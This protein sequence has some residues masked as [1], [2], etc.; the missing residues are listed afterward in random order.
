MKK[1][2]GFQGSWAAMAAASMVLAGCGGG[3]GPAPTPSPTPTPTPANAAPVFTSPTTTQFQSGVN[4]IAYFATATDAENDSLTYS[5][6]GGADQ[7]LFRISSSGALSFINIPLV[8]SPQDADRNNVYLVQISVSDGRNTVALNLAITVV[9]PTASISVRRVATGFSQ[10]VFLAPVPGG[11]RVFVVERTGKIKILNPQTGAV[12]AADF[13]DVSREIS[14]DGER[15]LLGFATAP[16]FATSRNFYVFLTNAGGTIEVRR[17]RTTAGNP[18]IADPLTA[19]IILSI[20]HPGFSNHNGGWIGFGPDGF[21][22]VGTGDG[23]GAGDPNGNAQNRNALLGKMLRIDPAR[24]DYPADANRDY[25]IPSTN[26]FA[27]GGGAPEVLALGLRNPFRNSF[28]GNRLYIGDVGQ[29]A[30]E[31]VDILLTT[32]GAINFGW[33]ILEG[34]RAFGSGSTSGLT[35][36]VLEYS[37]GSGAFEG[38]S[39]TGGIVYRGQVPSLQGQYVLGD[40]VQPRIW[41]IAAASLSR[42]TTQPSSALAD[43]RTAFAPNAGAFTNIVAFGTDTA[44]NLYIVDFDGEIFVIDPL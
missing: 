10:P 9:D 2:V 36:P 44:N 8:G 17:Y 18:D 14:T 43:R 34:T 30:V 38:S 12:A 22:Y 39:I 25:G 1:R 24:D 29:G 6:T 19:D 5:L 31:E 26:P 33:P 11:N 32:D 21:L 7:A 41:S 37:H 40:F 13:L 4:G 42:G 3:G 20:P 35:A 27:G 23:G 16:D 28:D 15:G